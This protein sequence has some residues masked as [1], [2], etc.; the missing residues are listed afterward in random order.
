[1]SER[2]FAGRGALALLAL[3]AGALPASAQDQLLFSLTSA[4]TAPFGALADGEIAR[5]D[6]VSGRCL[7]WLSMASGAFFAGDL[8]GDGATDEWKDVDALHVTPS[9]GRVSEVYLSFNATT[10]PWLDGDIVRVG[11]DGLLVLAWS[12]AQLIAALGFSDGQVDVDGFALAPDGRLL[13]SFAEDEASSLLSTDAIGVVTDGSIVSWDPVLALPGV[14]TT[15]GAIDALI[16]N[17]LGRSLKSGD[18]LGV[19]LDQSGLLCFTVQSPS[20]DDATVFRAANGGEVVVAEASLGVTGAPEIDALGLVDAGAEFLAARVTPR[21]VP[22]NVSAT[23]TLDGAAN[24]AFVMTLALARGD[25]ASFAGDGFIGLFLDPTDLLFAASLADF[26]FTWGVTDGAGQ[27]TLQFDP[28]P[29]G[30]T[31]TLFAQAYDFD[32]NTFGAPLALELE[33]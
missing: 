13:L 22:A 4:G 26:T 31:V 20:S 24:H 8:D 29:P 2:N 23:V 16:S 28:A 17:A 11:A 18:T 1:M 27:A 14:E 3:A 9:G 5:F 21:L 10:G 6:P 15:E 25:A 19:A 12:E 33:G 32:G 30:I 7:P